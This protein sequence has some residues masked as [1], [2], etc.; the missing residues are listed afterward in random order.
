LAGRP[1][2]QL[3]RLHSWQRHQCPSIAGS[4][5][6]RITPPTSRSPVTLKA[7][8]AVTP[9]TASTGRR[10]NPRR[11]T[12]PPPAPMGLNESRTTKSAV[13]AICN[14]SKSATPTSPAAWD[15]PPPT[16]FIG[17]QSRDMTTSL[18]S[19]ANTACISAWCSSACWT[20]CLPAPTPMASSYS[21]R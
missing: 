19:A 2:G 18:G 20:T 21:T 9:I 1:Q 16:T 10:S 6:D 11:S 13:R 17:P 14:R 8:R 7:I 15:Q 4:C 3:G 5:R 12:E